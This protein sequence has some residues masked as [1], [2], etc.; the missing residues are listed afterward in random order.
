MFI[1]D[2]VVDEGEEMIIDVIVLNVVDKDEFFDELFFMVVMLLCYGMIIDC[3]DGV[4]LLVIMFFLIQIMKVVLI[5]YQYDGSESI[6]DFFV[7]CVF[8]DKYNII[9]IILVYIIFVD[10][11]EL[12]LFVNVGLCIEVVGEI[13]IIML[14]NF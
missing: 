5:V 2:F 1:C 6:E 11:E 9:C 4:M 10:D 3:K 14:K 7:F 13:K 12:V 8:D